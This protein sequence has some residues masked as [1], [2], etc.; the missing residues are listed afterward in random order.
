MKQK[1][2]YLILIML[3][4]ICVTGCDLDLNAE[5]N[6]LIH[7][8]AAND[9]SPPRPTD[10]AADQAPEIVSELLGEPTGIIHVET[11]DTHTVEH[12][13]RLY[14]GI[15]L[16]YKDEK[17]TL[18]EADV[19]ER[20]RQR[21]KERREAAI[22]DGTLIVAE[23]ETTF[24]LPDREAGFR[25]IT[26]IIISTLALWLGLFVTKIKG[27][28][29]GMLACSLT[30]ALGSTVPYIGEYISAALMYFMIHQV[31]DAKFYPQSLLMLLLGKG[32][33]LLI[34]FSLIHHL[35]G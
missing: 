24:W 16:D 20:A 1:F 11:Q 3:S 26:T 34:V 17:L 28:F 7:P 14:N 18:P 27:T 30:A 19:L 8:N 13:T 21:I 22:L 33:T 5:L 9:Q 12:I 6:N 10:L 35:F 23:E 4:V 15:I 29:K 2:T 31:T 32:V 25:I